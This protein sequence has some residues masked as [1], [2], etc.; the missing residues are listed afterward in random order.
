MLSQARARRIEH[1]KLVEPADRFQ[2]HI[3]AGHG[4]PPKTGLETAT[5]IVLDHLDEI[6]KR[7]NLRQLSHR[8]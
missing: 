5:G 6:E 3:I 1:W 2:G 4:R 8:F 7:A